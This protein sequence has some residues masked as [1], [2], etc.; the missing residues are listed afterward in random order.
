MPL[1]YAY[2]LKC[3]SK[4]GSDGSPGGAAEEGRGREAATAVCAGVCGTKKFRM[5]EGRSP[6]RRRF[7]S[8]LESPLLRGLPLWLGST[9]R[10]GA[11]GK[12][13]P[14]FFFF[15]EYSPSLTPDVHGVFRRGFGPV[16]PLRG[17]RLAVR[18]QNDYKR[19]TPR[20]PHRLAVSSGNCG[21]APGSRSLT[22]ASCPRPGLSFGAARRDYRAD[23][24]RL[25]RNLYGSPPRAWGNLLPHYI[26]VSA[27]AIASLRPVSGNCLMPIVSGGH[28][29]AVVNAPDLRGDDVGGPVPP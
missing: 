24:S 23:L 5:G 11:L 18:G 16:L 6:P 14:P 12:R 27:I 19:L 17:L 13:L 7:P 15:P 20:G 25:H 4:T 1:L 21:M 9:E 22:P 8:R 28:G 10:A 29:D 3:R 26:P 2:C